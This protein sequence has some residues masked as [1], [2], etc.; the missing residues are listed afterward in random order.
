MS[1]RVSATCSCGAE[2]E[3][4]T[5]DKYGYIY[6]ATRWKEWLEHHAQCVYVTVRPRFR[7]DPSKRKR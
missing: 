3:Y 4:Q 6:V 1:E 5:T 2:F 7:I